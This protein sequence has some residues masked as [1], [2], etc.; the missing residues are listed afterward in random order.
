M[1][2]KKGRYMI[3]KTDYIYIGMGIHKERH[4]AVMLTYTE[5]QLGE[6]TIQN[7]LT[8]FKRLLTY[9]EKHKAHYIPVFSLEDITPYGRNLAIY[10]LEKD[11]SVKEVN[12]CQLV[13]LKVRFL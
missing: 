4:T 8:G 13:K 7:N 1:T 9:V 3:Q 6:I 5:E 10:L 12:Q 2:E 11:Y